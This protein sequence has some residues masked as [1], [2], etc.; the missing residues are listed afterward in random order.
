M[1]NEDPG[2][3]MIIAMEKTLA[4][5]ARKYLLCNRNDIPIVRFR[6][7]TLPKR[8]IIIDTEILNDEAIDILKLKKYQQIENDKNRIM[9]LNDKVTTYLHGKQR[10]YKVTGYLLDD[11]II[12]RLGLD[13]TVTNFG[14]L[15]GMEYLIDLL[16]YHFYDSEN[17]LYV[18]CEEPGVISFFHEVPGWKKLLFDF[19]VTYKEV[20]NTK[21]ENFSYV[22]ISQK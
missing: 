7:I 3:D 22:S 21:K 20:I 5:T 4:K 6:I 11:F 2:K 14:R 8:N 16:Q 10:D 18:T 13:S 12:N 1:E 19:P 15:N 17:E 9:Y